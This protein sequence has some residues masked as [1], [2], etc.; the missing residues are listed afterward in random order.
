MSNVTRRD[1]LKLGA[2][3]VAAGA[4]QKT[5]NRGKIVAAVDSIASDWT[6]LTDPGLAVTVVWDEDDFTK[7]YGMA[8]LEDGIPI[9][10]STT[11]NLGSV[12][13]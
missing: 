11:F 13:K 7:G 1:T 3:G 10:T 5:I 6:S 4:C 8:N 2:A 12:S 9:T